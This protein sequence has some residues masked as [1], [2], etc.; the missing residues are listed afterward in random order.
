M[1][2][3]TYL[4]ANPVHARDMIARIGTLQV[5]PQHR[6]LVT[7]ER[8]AEKRT[9]DQ[10]SKLRA[11]ERDI[12]AHVGHDPD[13]IHEILLAKRFGTKVVEA[14]GHRW[15]RPA[16]RSSDLSKQEMAEYITWVQAFA[17][18]ELGVA[19]R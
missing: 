19:L 9:N 14:A 5:T 1:S 18:T 11:M 8:L 4:I 16:K 15:E 7:I 17:A 6:W 3:Q 12:G 2:A 10:N 13:E